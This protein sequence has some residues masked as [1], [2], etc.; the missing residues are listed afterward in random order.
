[1]RSRSARVA[2]VC[3]MARADR[4]AD[5]AR[6]CVC[7][8]APATS[9]SVTRITCNGRPSRCPAA[10]AMA[11]IPAA[12][13]AVTAAIR[14]PSVAAYLDTANIRAHETASAAPTP[15]TGE[16]RMMATAE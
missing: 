9:P 15:A 4:S 11:I 7:S 5:S 12:M 10:E 3:S 16:E 14:K 2:L 13:A 8:I 6:D 1:M